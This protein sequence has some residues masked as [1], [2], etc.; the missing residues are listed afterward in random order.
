MNVS[1][2]LTSPLL[3]VA[4]A[5]GLVS[6]TNDLDAT[7]F[8]NPLGHVESILTSDAQRTALFNVLDQVLPPQT[9]TGAP[10][11]SKWHPLLDAQD[12]GNVYL[13]VDSSAST[14]L[15]FAAR[16]GGQTASVLA[17]VPL[18]SLSGSNVSAVAGTA[19]GPV[20]VSVDVEVGWSTPAHP[21]A[22]QNISLAV[23]YAPAAA[24]AVAS[25]VTTLRGLDLGDGDG[26]H[27]V[28]LDP[29]ELGGEAVTVIVGL[30]REK[31][32]DIAATATGEAAAIANHLI[33][34]LGLDGSLP[35]FPLATLASD[36]QAL[37]TWLQAL[38]SGDSP[39]L[40][41]WLGQLAGLLG[42]A[43][44][45]IT[46]TTSGK[47]TAWS[48]PLFAPNAA[49]SV[50][51]GLIRGLAADG[52]T[53]T[54]GLQI[55]AVI[56]P[57]SAAPAE[58]DA[59]IALFTAPLGGKA[60][61][62]TLPA[63]SLVVRA[64]AGSG[65]LIAPA[66]GAF[67]VDSVQAGIRWD[68]S[69]ISP[70]LELSNLV[71]PSAGSFPVIDLSNANTV[72]A[73]AA[74]ALVD[75]I[76]NG[77]GASGAGTQLAALAGLVEPSTD[78]AAPLVNI[79]Q[80]VT[81]PTAAIAAFH[82]AALISTTHP[83]SIYLSE[84]AALLS[85]PTAVTGTGTTADPWSV[86]LA[87][88]GPLSVAL[89]AWNAQTSGNPSD[90]QQL[91]IGLRG[92]AVT[93]TAQANW[94]S[95][96]LG[97]DLPSD[98]ANHVTLF[99]EHV[100][101]VT[102]QPP[103]AGDGTTQLSTSGI[104]VTFSMI[105]GAPIAVQAS[106]NQ[107]N[108]T[109]P[110]GTI[111]VPTLTVP[112]PA[113]FDPQNPTAALGIST[114]QL[115][116]LVI[117]TLWEA[118]ADALGPAGRALAVILGCGAGALG[119]P[120]DEPT[121]ADVAGGTLFTDPASSWREWLAAVATT[122]SAQ[123]GD[124][125]TPV[126]GW[127]AALLGNGLPADPS[128]PPDMTAVSGMG[129]YDD[130][131]IVPL[132][133]PT[134][135]AQG[136]LWFEPNGPSSAAAAA[137]ETI[138]AA[139]DFSTL[140]D[141]IG[142][143]SRYLGALP[144]GVDTAALAGGLQTLSTYLASSDGV[145]PISSQVPT[146]GSWGSGTLL[147]SAHPDQPSDPSAISQILA[148]IDTWAA[149]GSPRVVLLLGPAFS[150]HIIWSQLLSQAESAQS[151]ST[152]PTDA[153]FNLRVPGVAPAS[154]D[155]R[156]VTATADFYT[157]DLQDDG[158]N[159]VTGLAA[160]IG[161]IVGRLSAL[162]P[163]AP[164][165]LVAHSTV[166]VAARA[167][168]AANAA[169]V[170]GLVT[171]G[172]P[173][174]GAALTPLVD[175]ATADAV[176]LIFRWLPNGLP[177]GPLQDALQHLHTALDGY[178]P[179]P[180]A[181]ALPVPWPYPVADF[182]GASSTDTGG[183]PALALGGQLG[184]TTPVDLLSSL[185]TALAA[186]IGTFTA[187][188]PTHLGCG[189]QLQLP[190]GGTPGGGTSATTAVS[191]TAGLR[192]DV[193]RLA[194]ASGAPAPTRPAH[195]LTA[196]VSLWQ[197]GG[198][199]AGDARSYTGSGPTA[200]V[201]ARDAQFGLTIALA[202][203][204]QQGSPFAAMHDVAVDSPTAALIGWSDPL[205][206]P[207]LGAVFS[208]I[209]I[210]AG[211]A[212][213]TQLGNLLMLLQALGIATVPTDATTPIGIDADAINALTVDPIGFLAP[214][215]RAALANGSIPGF[216]VSGTGQ[217]TA[218]IGSLPLQAFIDM[219]VPGVG[220]RTT[221]SGLALGASVAAGASVEL[222]LTD[223]Q[224]VISANLSA[225]PVTLTYAGSALSVHVDSTNTSLSLLPAPTAA[226][227]ATAVTEVLPPLL[228]SG[229]GS[230]LLN[231]F[232]DPGYKITGLWSFL[233]APA[234]WLIGSGALGDGTA[235][236]PAKL[237]ALF[238]LIGTLPAGLTLAA[239]GT[240]PTTITLTTATPLGGVLT[241]DAGVSVDHTL[242][243]TPTAT[244]QISAPT[245]G[246]WPQIGVTFGLSG[247]G[248][249]LAV[250]PSGAAPI[251]LLPKF[252]GA[253]ALAGAAKKLLPE[254]L[255]ALL[256]AVAPATKPALVV[257]ALDVAA[258]LDVYDS[259][260]GFDAHADQ[261][262]A[263]TTAGWFN[264]LSTTTRT[265]F[266]TAAAAYFNDPTSPLNGQLPGT[267]TT[268][269]NT[270]SWAFS[271]PAAV[272]SGSIALNAG[273][274]NAGPTL[275]VTTTDLALA[276][277]PITT[278]LTAGYSGGTANTSGALDVSL[279]SSLGI[280]VAPRLA[281][282]LGGT[283]AAALTFAPLGAGTESTLSLQLAPQV[284]LTATTAAAGLLVEDWAVPLV[285]DLLISAT[286]TEFDEP[287][288]PGGPSTETLLSN[289]GLI[290]VGAGPAPQKYSLKTPL[291]QVDPVLTSLLQS[292]PPTPIALAADPPL[293]LTL[294]NLSGQL[295][296]A[297]QGSITITSGNPTIDVLFGPPP[298]TP[299]ASGSPAGVQLTLFS[300]GAS[301]AP[302]LNIGGIG[303]SFAGDGDQ[304]LI[305]AAG[306]RING[307]DAFVALKFDLT[308]A[309]TI[310]LGGGLLID[311]LGLPLGLL[312]SVTSSNPVAASI[313]GSD[314]G[315]GGGD[316]AAVNPAVDV[317]VTYL[318]GPLSIQFA[319]SS[320]PVVVPVHA[321]FGPLYI[322]QID[323]ALDGTN[324][325]T[326][327]VDGSVSIDGLNVGLD[328]LALQIPLPHV[329][330]PSDWSLD[331][332]GLAVGFNSGPVEISG[333]LR[334][335]PGPPIEYDGMLSAQIAGIGL[336]VVGS[337]SRP[338]DAQGGYTSLFMFVSLPIP[339][340]GPPF[341]FITGLGG[342]FG[343]N[344]SL[345]VPTD[346]NQ[347]DSFILVEAIDDDS[348]ANNPLGAL[349]QM[350]QQ[351]PPRR[352]ALWV[353]AGATLTSFALV[354]SV[355]IV[356]VAFDKGLDI[357][358]LGVS[359]MA[360]P[361]ESVAIASVELAVRARF[362][363][364]EQ[365]LSVQAQ[366]TDNSYLF[367]RDCQLTGGF[368]L[369][370]WYGEGQFVLTLGGY[371][372]VFSPPPQFPAVP[373]LGFNWNV[374]NDIVI[375]GG[376]YFALT[377]SCVMAGG[378]LSATASIGPVS[379]WFDAYVDFLVSWD[380]F[381]YQFDIG[382]QIGASFSMTICFFACVTI[383][384]SVSLG[385]SLS[386]AGPPFHG[387]VSIDVAIASITI[388]FGDAAQKPNYITDW[389]TFAG[390]YLTAGDPNNSAVSLQVTQ[391]LLPVDPPGA[392]PQPGT[393]T[394]PWQV[395][396]E[397]TLASTTRMP[398]TSVPPDWY[399]APITAPSNLNGLDLAPMDRL[400]VTSVHYVLLQQYKG[401][402]WQ[403]APMTDASDHFTVS[404]TQGFF[405]EATWHWTD[406]NHLPAAART[407]TAITG[408]SINAHVVLNN[409]SALIPISTLVADLPAYAKPLP[410]ADTANVLTFKAFGDDADSL[411]AAIAA[412]SSSTFLNAGAA[413]LSGAAGVFATNRAALGLPAAGLAP[414][415]TQALQTQRSA[416]PL[417]TPLT[418]GLSMKPVGLPAPVHPAAVAP[419][420]PVMLSQPR[421]RAVMQTVPTPVSDA[422]PAT[423]TSVTHL[424]PSLLAA[425]P[426]MAPP[427]SLTAPALPGAR[428]ITVSS[429]TAPRPT[430]AAQT[431]RALRNAAVGAAT[432]PAHQQALD[433]A[434]TD[435]T[436][437]GV[438]LGAGVTH[439]WDISDDSAQFSITGSGAV[440]I[441]CADRSG[442][443]LADTEFVATTGAVPSPPAGTA[444][445]AITCL[446]TLPAGAAAPTA[447]FAALTSIFAPT[448]QTAALGW[449]S[450]S[451]LTQIGPSRFLARGATLRVIQAH[452][453]ARN[454]QKASYGTPRASDVVND[455]IAVETRLPTSVEV[456]AV[457]LDI[458]DPT[459][460]QNGDLALAATG[461]T[462]ASTPQRVSTG[463]R[464]L[465]LYDV[466]AT[467]P[468]A[469]ALLI[470]VSS[471]TGYRIGGVIGLPGVASEWATRLS[472]GLPDQFVPDGPFTAAGSLTVTYPGAQP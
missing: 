6:A 60:A 54:L 405:P 11:A 385:A 393:S 206:A 377:N 19:G 282:T 323:L 171:V 301:F 270:F 299:N 355:V 269:G 315:A 456:I 113:G 80:L 69:A 97:A 64:P 333:G 262:A 220:L 432:G 394:Q 387:S 93:P 286:G 283:T 47:T 313:L 3:D 272:G 424:Q 61:A 138:T 239:T 201:R 114:A 298:G 1:G 26:P 300:T 467:D 208:A 59:R 63:A 188:A 67:S 142:G 40:A 403:S 148:Q 55:S 441:V 123:G 38:A 141:G 254:A 200:G 134:S 150:D 152:N 276:D 288:Y 422:P 470:A 260:G 401:G 182:D 96:L 314:P 194:L 157:A 109:T 261:L 233:Q 436:G 98:G 464:Q 311:Q 185:Q 87:S 91:R 153:F 275:G 367:S 79:T 337:Y 363:S 421:L 118:L 223:L 331:L 412:V 292:L 277:G 136:L 379:A 165:I 149:A 415:A 154:I 426:R 366:L 156:P 452:A 378:S 137:A 320:Q 349:M 294:G 131:W 446:G 259:T 78:T 115:E 351:I 457:A 280:D 5:I 252:D 332:Q 358:I 237:T 41:Q 327:G 193:G 402:T 400:N 107:L 34:L 192:I 100:A 375:K 466:T 212:P 127:L 75:T 329:L 77:L 293:T 425:S 15:G 399:G 398:V 328:D 250:N 406:P 364:A 408:L 140:M 170:K 416:P 409:E 471:V 27:D 126:L 124:Y 255:D 442:T 166:G 108:L 39:P 203:S 453:T 246:T 407:I 101:T 350:S 234:Q 175:A 37:V 330:T 7:W 354:N 190:L 297:I 160:Q 183:V 266:I 341:A 263:M 264:T 434:A 199:L 23:V 198:W 128:L 414:L 84:L 295:G 229:I 449:Q 420:D 177:A 362:N 18:V 388:G 417:L 353:A 410:F 21:I 73:S 462:L 95:V 49:S 302:A 16:Y 130:P 197:P 30:I 325:V 317:E 12:A 111:T 164:L 86:P 224:P 310:G 168:T 382:V 174:Q 173:H 443:P 4:Q 445:V 256:D 48:V 458:T 391:G 249:S 447:G 404:A 227:V 274:D 340:G 411:A 380:P 397:F 29:A 20:Q 305:N 32:H 383:G 251:E 243:A 144:P 25:V 14:V 459:A 132:G 225:G 45:A 253:A 207:G 241:V 219:S 214:K 419:M 291:P 365:L 427:G 205:F 238:G 186:Q 169:T 360:L 116:S 105:A 396:I 392:Q 62:Q 440:R 308:Q 89:V 271:L 9:V 57:S 94:T 2:V 196:T 71:I 51:L 83:W 104:D 321:N 211:A 17:Q 240:D 296:V 303:A 92:Q 231:S 371:N 13:T 119:L 352:G 106:I 322:D 230:T 159:D 267:I 143:A 306:V 281:F 8:E 184:G 117:A 52:V 221:G 384:V 268:S 236:D 210:G 204:T 222:P 155:L 359:R 121:L 179:P 36:P 368:A 389:G 76:L 369:V 381:A 145:V 435:L 209:G 43:A 361:T 285:A 191:A 469:A 336:T 433:Q 85:L 244:L 228:I 290:N 450:A 35:A 374:S 82:R 324:T 33:P 187:V 139:I 151:G 345:V 176:R 58:L 217:F 372:P 163:G 289:A 437:A 120:S 357:E 287:I 284:K 373:R 438:T 146:G 278:S 460:V 215:L 195:A 112:L 147:G 451:T 10:P 444:M 334:K 158:T 429:A 273:W 70:L 242:H 189:V 72:I 307:I 247:G 428:L 102:L 390:K 454:A 245:D 423:H 265:A 180:S 248:L 167:Y 178:L 343:Y 439:L 56:A 279:S 346:M 326:V 430:R 356:S 463:N 318:G 31:L 304:P 81:N 68:G 50:E 213:G 257:L 218:P 395:G 370:V 448:G 90:P 129:S 88:V 172:T 74:S 133:D 66:T 347:I 386:I 418:T 162:R 258:A 24:P 344:R 339:L 472:A 312:D 235:F 309:T 65:I 44:P 413:I 53:A 316:A 431:A 46:T 125:L 319:G 28:T 342:G 226:E 42:I 202:G 161:L 376:A 465:L 338:S 468:A 99:A 455:Q 335:N 181:S 216:T 122:A 135:T 110:S 103:A 461:A 348:L 232:L 22:L